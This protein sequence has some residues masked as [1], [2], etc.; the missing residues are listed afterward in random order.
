MKNISTWITFIKG[1]YLKF[2][3][4]SPSLKTVNLL[5]LHRK[6]IS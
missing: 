5:M 4:N 6:C 2:F 3:S 1:I